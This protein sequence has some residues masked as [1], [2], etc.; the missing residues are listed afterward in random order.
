MVR[1]KDVNKA[2]K[3]N[4]LMNTI[5]LFVFI[6]GYFGGFINIVAW[7]WGILNVIQIMATLLLGQMIHNQ[8]IR[9]VI[10]LKPDLMD[11]TTKM[12]YMNLIHTFV[13]SA[14]YLTF[15]TVTGLWHLFIIEWVSTGSMAVLK[16]NLNKYFRIK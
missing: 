14:V 1:V 10:L 2:E 5:F 4:Y 12:V 7:I 15:F 11:L 16:T 6:L 9:N 13:T 3:D 8:N